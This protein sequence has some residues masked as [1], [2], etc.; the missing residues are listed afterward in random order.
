MIEIQKGWNFNTADFSLIASGQKN[1][2]GTVHLIRE[3]SQK[4]LWHEQID[5][6]E[7]DLWPPLY[8]TGQGK[9][10]EEA[11][12]CANANA[13]AIGILSENAED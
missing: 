2:N 10:I 5:G 13:K 3:P 8:A 11:V 1:R 7:E 6:I 12:A 4:E 9:T